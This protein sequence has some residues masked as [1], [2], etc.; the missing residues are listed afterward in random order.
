[1]SRYRESERRRS[2]EGMTLVEI[3][4]V[5]IIMA[6]IAT[7]VGVAVLPKVR[8][9]R[10]ESTRT[11]AA[12]IRSA[13]ESYLAGSTQAGTGCPTLEDLLESGELRRGTRT[14]D[15]WDN[16]FEIQCQGDEIV[17]RSAGPDGQMGT[18]DDVQ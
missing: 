10:I 15:A 8:Q 5:V 2:R 1:M 7:A 6:L 4:V 13:V 11:D 14:T 16:P 12:T 9:A 3:M 17:V 18:E